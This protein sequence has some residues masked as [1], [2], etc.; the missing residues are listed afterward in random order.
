MA[1]MTAA[2]PP[3]VMLFRPRLRYSSTGE[4]QFDAMMTWR[5]DLELGYLDEDGN[6]GDAPDVVGGYAEFL[7]I[8]VGVCCTN[9]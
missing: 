9:R 7:I 2:T 8:N 1:E 3:Y 4:S 6:E 5:A